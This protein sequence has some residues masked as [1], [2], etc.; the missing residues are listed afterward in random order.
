MEPVMFWAFMGI[1]AWGCAAYY[2]RR[3]D[4]WVTEATE[5]HR[6]AEAYYARSQKVFHAIHEAMELHNYGATLEARVLMAQVQKEMAEP[7]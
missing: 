3:A 7:W 2:F 6:R 5:C 4:G 1:V